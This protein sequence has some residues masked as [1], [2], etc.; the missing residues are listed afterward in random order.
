MREEAR[1][2]TLESQM[3]RRQKKFLI[4]SFLSL[5]GISTTNSSELGRS[6]PVQGVGECGLDTIGE[7]QQELLAK[8]EQLLLAPRQARAALK[9]EVEASER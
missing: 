1:V 7:M 4:S 3:L 5:N 9:V 8:Q 6:T 2:V